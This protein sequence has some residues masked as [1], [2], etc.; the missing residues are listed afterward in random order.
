M[1]S[2]HPHEDWAETFAHYLHM[3]DTLETA[4]AFGLRIRPRAGQDKSYAKEER[5][6]SSA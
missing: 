4:Y 1:P 5:T 2:S 3:L 6:F